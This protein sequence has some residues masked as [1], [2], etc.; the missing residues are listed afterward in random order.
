MKL[1]GQVG[2]EVYM[3][4]LRW[5][6]NARRMWAE[7]WCAKF[8]HSKL[9]WGMIREVFEKIYLRCGAN[10]GDSG[11]LRCN[12][13]DRWA[14]GCTWRS[15]GGRSMPAVDGERDGVAPKKPLKSQGAKAHARVTVGHCDETCRRGG[16]WGVHDAPEAVGQCPQWMGREMGV[17]FFHSKLL[18]GIIREVI[19]KKCYDE[20]HTKVWWNLQQRW[21]L[22]CTWRSWGGR[23]MSAGGGVKKG[24]WEKE[25]NFFE[26]KLEKPEKNQKKKKK[27]KKKPKN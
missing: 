9:V 6:V 27:K 22:R 10:Q 14:W 1:A 20:A 5:Q 3:T 15:W 19:E 21:A 13:H 18:W 16:L 11:A 12:L 2:F 17:K 8:F 4:P 7:R 25:K 23:S 24:C 26:K